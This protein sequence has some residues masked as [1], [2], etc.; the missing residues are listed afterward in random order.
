MDETGKELICI[1]TAGLEVAF[2]VRCFIIPPDNLTNWDEMT[3]KLVSLTQ[4]ELEK[5]P[6][7]S[8][9]LCGESFGGCL[10]LKVL[11]TLR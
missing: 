1:Q 2:D 10:A 8:V 7:A 5:T 11:S 4:I 3:I 9:Y 6:R